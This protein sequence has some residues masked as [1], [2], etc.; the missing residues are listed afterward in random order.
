MRCPFCREEND[1]VID[2]RLVEDGFSIRRRRHCLRCGRRYT[3]SERPEEMAIKVVKKGGCREPFQRG[4]IRQGLERACWK[5]PI[6]GEQID[7]LVSDIE[8]EVYADFESEIPSRVLGDL[9]MEHLR[10]LDQVAYVRFAS[11][12]REFKDV[13]DFV[14]ELRPILE[15]RDTRE[16]T[17]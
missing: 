2:S 4:K 3:T 5:R 1:R 16:R 12:Y 9:V 11:V 17:S 6:S 8:S 15:K 10:Q 13:A 14:Q 7:G